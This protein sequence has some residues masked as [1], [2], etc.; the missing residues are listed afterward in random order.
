[1]PKYVHVAEIAAGDVIKASF[2]ALAHFLNME[3]YIS[4]E[5]YDFNSLAIVPEPY[6][7]YKDDYK[8]GVEKD[9]I[10][11]NIG[12]TFLELVTIFNNASNTG[13]DITRKCDTIVKQY[14]I[15][16]LNLHNE[17]VLDYYLMVNKNKELSSE[18]FTGEKLH[19]TT[20]EDFLKL[21]AH[22]AL[23]DVLTSHSMESEN[24]SFKFN[25][26]NRLQNHKDK[27]IE[28]LIY[29]ND[30]MPPI[31]VKFK[32]DEQFHSANNFYWQLRKEFDGVASELKERE[33]YE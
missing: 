24:L 7:I 31:M 32:Y 6:M 3:D 29:P 4:L 25:T 27:I 21:I 16:I 30:M 14:M 33:K 8:G 11:I 26:A 13:D 5:F 15:D 20:Q 28:F 9:R 23:Y 2:Y 22:M 19:S 17:N 10:N 1:M 12:N 18:F